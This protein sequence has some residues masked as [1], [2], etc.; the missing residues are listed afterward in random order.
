MAAQHAEGCPSLQ[1]ASAAHCRSVRGPCRSQQHRPRP[2]RQLMRTH[3]T[4]Y[5]APALQQRQRE[6]QT[7]TGGDG[8][9]SWGWGGGGGGGRP[10]Q[11]GGSGGD[12]DD[13][14]DDAADD[15]ISST[16]ER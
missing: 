12:Q 10:P 14:D 16:F 2:H 15:P 1:T 3:A 7:E 13:P 4:A 8:G 5:E 11:G 6:A 9:G